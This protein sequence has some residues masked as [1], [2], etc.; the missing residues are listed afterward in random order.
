MACAPGSPSARRR[1][2]GVYKGVQQDCEPPRTDFRASTVI[3]EPASKRAVPLRKA[4]DVDVLRESV[5]SMPVKYSPATTG[6][7]QPAAQTPS[8]QTA[9]GGAARAALRCRV[10]PSALSPHEPLASL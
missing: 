3:S 1:A 8:K 2:A 10:T 9:K 7:T 5:H 6:A 4:P